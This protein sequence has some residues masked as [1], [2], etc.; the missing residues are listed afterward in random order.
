M[1]LLTS[2][3]G[4]AALRCNLVISHI[5]PGTSGNFTIQAFSLRPKGILPKS[6]TNP[7][8]SRTRA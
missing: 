5:V 1:D 8:T 3:T 7:V 2:V 4:Y 6:R